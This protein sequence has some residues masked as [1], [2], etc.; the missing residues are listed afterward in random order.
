[1]SD[2]DLDDSLGLLE[3]A[4]QNALE[5]DRARIVAYLDSLPAAESEPARARRQ[6][7]R[8]ALGGS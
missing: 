1:M 7:L 4:N 5:V 6:T 2:A 3:H 8:S